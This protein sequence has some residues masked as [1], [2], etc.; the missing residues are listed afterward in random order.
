MYGFS[1]LPGNKVSG[2]IYGSPLYPNGSTVQ[3]SRIV[4]APIP[5]NNTVVSTRS[6]SSYWLSS[7]PPPPL[8]PDLVRSNSDPLSSSSS[9]IDPSV[10]RLHGAFVSMHQKLRASGYALSRGSR[11]PSTLGDFQKRLLHL[12][13]DEELYTTLAK[14]QS[15]TEVLVTFPRPTDKGRVSVARMS[16]IWA[17]MSELGITCAAIV[18]RRGFSHSSK[19]KLLEL[20]ELGG[21]FKFF[22]ES[23]LTAAAGVAL[24]QQVIGGGGGAAYKRRGGGGE[25]SSGGGTDEAVVGKRGGKRRGR[26]DEGMLGGKRSRTDAAVDLLAGNLLML[27]R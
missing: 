18:L 16:A 24:V 25:D 15:R 19:A 2:L 10:R 20:R 12:P 23:D 4:S 17:K 14:P 26:D 8:L 22:Y 6:G 27:M 1:V 3:T 21:R 9:G 5:A 11:P 13:P 7:S